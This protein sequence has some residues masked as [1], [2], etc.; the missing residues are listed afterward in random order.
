MLILSPFFLFLFMSLFIHLYS[1]FLYFNFCITYFNFICTNYIFR[2]L[3][4]LLHEF[5]SLLYILDL[6]LLFYYLLLILNYCKVRFNKLPF[7]NFLYVFLYEFFIWIFYMYFLYKFLI[8]IFI[9]IFYI[10][11][12]YE[13]LYK[14]FIYFCFFKY[15]TTMI[16]KWCNLQKVFYLFYIFT[17]IFSVPKDNAKINSITFLISKNYSSLKPTPFIIWFNISKKNRTS[18]SYTHI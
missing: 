5:Y 13:F 2:N 7:N 8:W 9:W 16:S 1:I 10:N 11:F 14:F 17:V 15:Y 18:N 12:L 3:N 4:K 6:C